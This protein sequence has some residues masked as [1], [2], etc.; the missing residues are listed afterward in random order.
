MIR[1][2]QV[3]TWYRDSLTIAQTGA[4][5]FLIA[6]EGEF[7]EVATVVKLGDKSD[8]AFRTALGWASRGIAE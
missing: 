1:R 5:D 2:M 3:R 8:V 6:T 7:Q 4:G